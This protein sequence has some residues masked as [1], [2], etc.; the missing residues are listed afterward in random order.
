MMPSPWIFCGFIAHALP[1]QCSSKACRLSCSRDKFS[2]INII[3]HPLIY[4]GAVQVTLREHLKVYHCP[5]H[6]KLNRSCDSVARDILRKA[7][8]KFGLAWYTP[9]TTTKVSKTVAMLGPAAWMAALPA[10]TH[11]R[12][13]SSWAIRLFYWSYWSVESIRGRAYNTHSV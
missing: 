6:M 9:R 11:G 10:S 4:G 5:S 12:Q 7:F 13:L 8:A 3:Y 1:C 2:H